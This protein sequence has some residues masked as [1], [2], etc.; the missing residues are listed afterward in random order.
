MRRAGLLSFAF[1]AK[2]PVRPPAV[3]HLHANGAGVCRE[4]WD[5]GW[6]GPRGHLRFADTARFGKPEVPSRSGT[7]A[8]YIVLLWCTFRHFLLQTGHRSRRNRRVHERMH[9]PHAGRVRDEA[10]CIALTTQTLARKAKLSKPG[11]QVCDSGRPHRCFRVGTRGE[12]NVCLRQFMVRPGSA[13][14]VPPP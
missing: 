5:V 2:A 6:R 11:I 1:L 13:H 7:N 4:M 14:P 9:R 10:G 12:G 3:A 8:F